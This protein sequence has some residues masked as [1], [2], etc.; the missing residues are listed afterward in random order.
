MRALTLGSLLLALV[1]ATD[2]PTATIKNGSYYGLYQEAYDQHL[3]LGMPYAQPPVG[4]LRFRVPQSPNSTWTDV[5]N[6]TEYSPECYG[7]GSDQWVLG[8]VISEDCLTINVVRPSNV[9]EGGDLPV[10]GKPFIGVS[11]NYRLQAFGFLWGTAVK[12][13]GV[14]NLGFRDQ[15]LALHWVQENIAAF[16]GDATKVTI[17]GESAGA[18][19]VSYQLIA[20]GGRDDGLFRG[21]VMQSGSPVKYIPGA[22]TNASE[23]D[24][25]YNNITAAANCSAAA[26][27]LACLRLV[28]VETLS[29][30]LNSSVASS[31]S[32]G[33]AV[34]GDYIEDTG[35]A[36]LSEGKFVRVP[37]LLG[38]NNDEGT[39]FGKTGIDTTEEFFE[40]LV[41]AK[42]YDQAK[43]NLLLELY[44]DIP[45][46]GI[47]GTL[48][49]RPGN[50]TSYGAMYKRVSA[51][52]GDSTMHA[53]R[54]FMSEIWAANGL[55]SYSYRVNVLSAGIS[56]YTG[57]TH[58]Q[59][60]AF[61]FYNLDGNGYNNSVA[62][63]PFLNKPDSY[64]QLAR[65]MTRMWASFIVDQ[66][67]NNN[68]VTDVEWPQYSLDDPQNIVCDAN[69]TD[70][71]Y[72]ES[73]LF[74]A[75]AI[76]YMINNGV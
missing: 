53:P 44:P 19:G 4:D 45:E 59:E 68:G 46:I 62:T 66:T 49:S 7:Y 21:A 13:A 47:P 64:K 43:A 61:V 23:W 8:N 75:E 74:R 16:G 55:P 2:P 41:R 18:R 50:D 30:I 14:T 71:A 76:A 17:W 34:D 24:V 70:L 5:K 11:F 1:S 35:P 33:P 3:F 28:P 67:P 56:Q 31:A 32:W 69:V 20:Y 36:L 52:A 54:R 57:S 48:H 25:Y 29:A 27:T 65:V 10:A 22:Y 37:I 40:Y 58:F 6:A 72:I 12:E 63:D 26:D 51:Y 60:V 9:S 38:T 42:G 39:A 15:R 73:D